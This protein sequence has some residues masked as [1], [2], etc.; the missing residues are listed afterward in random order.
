M[1]DH[2]LNLLILGFWTGP[3]L[4]ACTWAG[5]MEALVDLVE[6]DR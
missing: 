5:W 4:L 1:K 2:P 6:V 3:F